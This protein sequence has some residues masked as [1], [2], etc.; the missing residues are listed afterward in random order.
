M[1]MLCCCCTASNRMN[2]R[3]EQD[4]TEA[5]IKSIR[6]INQRQAEILWCMMGH[7]D[8][9]RRLPDSKDRS[10]PPRGTGLHQEG[11]ARPG[12]CVCR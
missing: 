3:S 12:V 2:V 9:R 8:L 4:R 6:G 7:G 10:P 5:I 11:E 1:V